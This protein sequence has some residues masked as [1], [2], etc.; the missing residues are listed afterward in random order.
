MSL[1]PV[2]VAYY[3][4]EDFGG[5]NCKYSYEECC[6]V[7]A[8][9][10]GLIWKLSFFGALLEEQDG[11]TGED[12]VQGYFRLWCDQPTGVD[13]ITAK[14][15][16]VV[17]NQLGEIVHKHNIPTKT[18]KY[19]DAAAD[20]GYLDF[21]KWPKLERM[22]V[23]NALIVEAVIQ[24]QGGRP[25]YLPKNPFG[26]NM[27]KLLDSD[28]DKD[29]FFN[30]DG[31]IV[32]A[33]KLILKASSSVLATLCSGGSSSKE[34]PIHIKDTKPEVFRHLLNF[35]YGGNLGDGLIVKYGREIIDL[36]DRFDV[37]GLKMSAEAALVRSCKK[38]DVISVDNTAEWIQYADSKT[39]PL[40]KEY[41]LSYF[42]A[43]YRDV[44]KTE[45]YQS[46]KQCPRLMEEVMTAVYNTLSRAE[47]GTSKLSVDDLR[48]S[49]CRI[50]LDVDGSKDT[51]VSRL[52]AYS[53]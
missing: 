17:R 31:E 10:R 33:H 40:L 13:C 8:D 51:L 45:S 53:S 36:C 28:E 26:Q 42:V 49:L 23:D 16:L 15:T 19:N 12:A 14:V 29:V 27:L 22:L 2:S 6:S 20:I 47:H 32:S 35:L 39:C 43:W 37:V 21:P 18:Y 7:V 11:T 4:L 41:A 24:Y 34:S 25:F 50:G 1:S 48:V 52:D 3:K 5:D 44:L 46:L 38:G 9:G 30:V